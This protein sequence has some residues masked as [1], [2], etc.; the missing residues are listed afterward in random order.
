[1]WR[2]KLEVKCSS[3]WQPGF[4]EAIL[5]LAFFRLERDRVLC[6]NEQFRGQLYWSNAH[7]TSTERPLPHYCPII[8]KAIKWCPQVA[9]RRSPLVNDCICPIMTRP[10]L[11]RGPCRLLPASIASPSG[12]HIFEEPCTLKN[13]KFSRR[14]INTFVEEGCAQ[15]FRLKTGLYGMTLQSS[16]GWY[17]PVSRCHLLRL[18]IDHSRGLTINL[19]SRTLTLSSWGRFLGKKQPWK[20][21]K[22]EVLIIRY[23]FWLFVAEWLCD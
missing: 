17:E 18:S 4:S 21:N 16:W 22:N 3:Y 11:W 14:V 9:W 23:S 15:D 6:E 5:E 19:F 2:G 13:N 12:T 1:M 20:H 8:P 7:T 10:R